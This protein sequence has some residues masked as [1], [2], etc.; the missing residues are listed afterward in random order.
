MSDSEQA[1]Q[2]EH[3]NIRVVDSKSQEI[4][5]FKIKTIAKLGKLMDAYA[6][7][8]GQIKKKKKKKK[9]K[10]NSIRFM[11]DGV[12]VKPEDTPIELDMNNNDKIEVMIEQVGGTKTR[13]QQKKK[14]K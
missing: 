5:F 13:Y 2:P 9:K 7:R 8:S 1:Q 6:K 11:F 14:N 12:K 4:F 10:K 3:I